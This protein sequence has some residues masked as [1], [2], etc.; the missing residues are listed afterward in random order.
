M[1]L[2]VFAYFY[3]P[4]I[5]S[6]FGGGT[7]IP[8]TIY[9]TKDSV[10]LPNQSTAALLIDESDAGLYVVGK[11]DKK[12]TFIPRNVVALVHFSNNASDFSLGSAKNNSP[13]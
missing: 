9:F 4:H 7:P 2:F 10:I 8:V 12:A 6:S 3:Y 13:K 1:V 11:N 5:K